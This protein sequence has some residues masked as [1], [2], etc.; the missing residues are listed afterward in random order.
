MKKTLR[1]SSI[2]Y[3]CSS[4]IQREL[5]LFD[6]LYITGLNQIGSKDHDTIREK[7][8]RSW[9][10]SFYAQDRV[11]LE[12]YIEMLFQKS[13]IKIHEVDF[14]EDRYTHFQNNPDIWEQFQPNYKVLS[15]YVKSWGNKIPDDEE[16]LKRRMD[17]TTRK[18]HDEPVRGMAIMLMNSED[19]LAI[20]NKLAYESANLFETKKQSVYNFIIEDIPLP[21]SENPFERIIEFKQDEASAQSLIALRNWIS[22]ISKSSLN[23]N[24]IEEKYHYLKNQYERSLE[25]HKMK[26]DNNLMETVIIGG[27]EILENIAR[28]KFSEAAKKIFKHKND[29][30]DLMENELKAEG[31]QLSYI[32]KIK[33]QPWVK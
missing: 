24:E 9:R 32:T 1:I 26:T 33:A 27:A 3:L 22:E 7:V 31:N 11:K 8:V 29:T 23:V 20:P 5:L 16:L 19:Y 28:L 6:E 17:I 21:S 14:I 15:D 12:E 13:L 2:D 30:I 4:N 10:S 18:A 25:L